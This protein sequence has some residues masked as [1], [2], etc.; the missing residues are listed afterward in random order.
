[1]RKFLERVKATMDK[2]EHTHR[3]YAVKSTAIQHLTKITTE[4]M[5]IIAILSGPICKL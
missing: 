4:I 5:I 3:A 1:M 2:N